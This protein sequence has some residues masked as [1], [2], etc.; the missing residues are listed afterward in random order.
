MQTVNNYE[1]MVFNGNLGY[2]VDLGRK[3][4][5]PMESDLPSAF[6]TV[7]MADGE[8]TKNVT[9]ADNEIKQLKL[10]WCS[11][12]HKFQGSQMKNVL[13]VLTK[14]HKFM[15]SRELVYT[16]LT[17][18]EKRVVIVGH[19]D[20]LYRAAKNSRIAVR[21]TNMTKMI[22]QGI[23]GTDNLLVRFPATQPTD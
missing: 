10:A 9:Y 5:D 22:R 11:T 17:R 4:I 18:A 19:E 7:R 21:H 6:V 8:T 23:E 15:A 13:F 3:V 1:K 20:M 12:V 16:A 2:V 14:S